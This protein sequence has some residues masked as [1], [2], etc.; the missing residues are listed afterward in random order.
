MTDMESVQLLIDLLDLKPGQQVLDLGCGAGGISEYISDQTETQVTGIDYSKVAISTANAR[1]ETNR[2][3]QR[4]LEAD[5]NTLALPK[6]SFDAAILVDSIYWVDDETNV[7]K[8]II[9]MLKPGGKLAILIV[10]LLEYCDTPEELEIDKNY[11]AS[12]LNDLR[13][14]YESRDVTD[15]FCNFWPRAKESMLALKDDFKRE[16]NGYICEHWLR[17]ANDEFLPAIEANELRRYL[18]LVRV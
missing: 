11:I 5:L 12:A 6:E 4:F 1:T 2:S 7:Q 8:R 17:E 13:L 10:H 3:R 16:G 18:Y 14:N 15:V 9:E